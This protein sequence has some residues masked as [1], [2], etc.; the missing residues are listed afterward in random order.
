MLSSNRLLALILCIAFPLYVPVLGCSFYYPEVRTSW[1]LSGGYLEG[2]HL[3]FLTSYTLYKKPRGI[4]AFPDGGISKRLFDR[5]YLYRCNLSTGELDRLMVLSERN[6]PGN[7]VKSCVFTRQESVLQLVYRSSNRLEPK[8]AGWRAVAWDMQEKV[9][10]TLGEKEKTGLI[11]SQREKVDPVSHWEIGQVKKTLED[12]P[13][14]RWG[15]PS[16]LDYCEKSDR[17]YGDDLVQLRG[18]Q[19]YRDAI[20][21]GIVS[22][23]IRLDVSRILERI[24]Q[25]KKQLKGYRRKAYE[26]YVKETEESL[27]GIQD[28]R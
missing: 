13:L 9:E 1:M 28:A 19:R 20:I 2:N 17:A 14:K 22:G 11:E 3:Y 27:R 10:V 25:R 6:E 4:A 18:D 26:I 16:A 23:Q 5:T 24:D 21:E 12:V 7:D 15:L 8:G